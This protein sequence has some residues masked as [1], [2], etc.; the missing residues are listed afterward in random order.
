MSGVGAF[1]AMF[2]FGRRAEGAQAAAATAFKPAHHPQDEWLEKIPGKHRIVVDVTSAQGVPTAVG[3]VDN[4]YTAH[5]SGYGLEEADLAIV[6]ILRH[7]ATAF[8]F[9]DAIWA[10]HSKALADRAGY[11]DPKASEPPKAHPFK[12]AP[13]TGFEGLVKRG[14]QFGV[15]DLSSHSI[16]RALAG[17]GDADATYK[18]MVANMIPSSRL[19]AAGVIGLTHAQEYGYTLVNV[20]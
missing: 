1:A 6:V 5:K 3:W 9:D 15:C 4:L 12:L 7:A 19:V 14:A 17:S 20:G 2:A 8:G 13:R 11:S 18:E 10:R 16:A